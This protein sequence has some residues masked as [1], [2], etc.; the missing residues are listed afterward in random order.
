MY[1]YSAI[2]NT[3]D[4]WPRVELIYRSIYL[5][6]FLTPFT[7]SSFFSY[8]NVHNTYCTNIEEC[9][10]LD[11]LVDMCISNALLSI[12]S[13]YIYPIHIYLLIY[14]HFYQFYLNLSIYIF[15]FYLSFYQ[16]LSIL[17][18]MYIIW[19]FTTIFGTHDALFLEQYISYI[20][21]YFYSS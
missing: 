14:S 3:Y 18:Y 12:Y 1:V 19:F 11:I 17:L 8:T 4:P 5:F 20:L 16:Y 9:Y 6:P 7:F 15:W 13:F 21:T 2:L 10:I